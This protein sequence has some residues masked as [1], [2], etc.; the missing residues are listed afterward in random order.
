M[1]SN[2][3]HLKS[4]N[5]RIFHAIGAELCE[6]LEMKSSE[7]NTEHTPERFADFWMDFSSYTDENLDTVFPAPE[8]SDWVIVRDIKG[9]SICE[10]HLLPFLIDVTIGYKPK[11]YIL[12]LS[13][14]AR[15]AKYHA[16]RPQTQER[17]GNA[18]LDHILR[19]TVSN[20]VFVI[21]DGFH[22]CMYGRGIESEA[23]TKSVHVS[24]SLKDKDDYIQKI[25][26]L[27]SI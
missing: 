21:I 22:L 16:H 14:F 20:E 1:P 8:N 12:G 7:P 23:R 2:S 17:L 10:H 13:K 15:I 4:K 25:S 6:A 5:W 19:V 11:A 18:I 24:N 27:V 9:M 26:Q 3:K